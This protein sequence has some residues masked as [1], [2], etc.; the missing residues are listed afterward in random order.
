M[1]GIDVSRIELE[2]SVEIGQTSLTL[3]QITHLGAGDQLV[4]DAAADGPHVLLAG[5]TA[6]GTC[7]L[8]E[9]DGM[10]GAR[11]VGLGAEAARLVIER[12]AA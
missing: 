2:I 10:W 7:D 3:G 8:V 11:V 6:I 1:N 4:L 12:R 9:I 5:G